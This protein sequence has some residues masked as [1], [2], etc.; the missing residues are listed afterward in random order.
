MFNCFMLKYLLSSFTL[1]FAKRGF[2]SRKTSILQ[3]RYVVV[4]IYNNFKHIIIQIVTNITLT[5]YHFKT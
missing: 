5:K 3:M 4:P 1:S 2:I